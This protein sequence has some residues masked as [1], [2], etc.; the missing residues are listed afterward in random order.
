[1]QGRTLII[2]FGNRYRRDDGVAAVVV[3][4]V[5]EQLGRPP[6][7]PLE[8]GF[9]DLGHA[10]DTVLLMQIVPELAELLASYERVIFVD[11]HTLNCSTP[12]REEWLQPQQ[13]MPLVSHHVH[14]ATVL[15]LTQRMTGRAP[16]GVL[17]S[18]RGHDFDFGEGLSSQTA[19]LVP[20]AAQRIL[21]LCC[22]EGH[23]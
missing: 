10:V 9:D 20:A 23:G 14:P 13:R 6:L 5:R 2:G 11:A 16:Q 15:E 17:L 1:M 4:A 7:G 3:N 12:L 22:G 8:D 19:T 21:S 18:L